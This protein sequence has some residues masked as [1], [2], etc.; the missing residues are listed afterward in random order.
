MRSGWYEF[1]GSW[2]WG[3]PANVGHGPWLEVYETR[4]GQ[5]AWK[6]SYVGIGGRLD[7]RGGGD[8]CPDVFTAMA[9][10]E[11]TFFDDYEGSPPYEGAL[12]LFFE[13]GGVWGVRRY[14]GTAWQGPVVQGVSTCEFAARAD[15]RLAA[16]QF[17]L[18]EACVGG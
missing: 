10:A 2:R 11:V 12:E 4:G 15:A 9:C 17:L 5:Y 1:A 7:S 14:D 3:G 16:A 18:E 6:R 13:D 8:Y